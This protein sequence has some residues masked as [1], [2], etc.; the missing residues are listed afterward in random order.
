M[1]RLRSRLEARQRGSSGSPRTKRRRWSPEERGG[2]SSKEWV[3]FERGFLAE[4]RRRDLLDV[5]PR[6]PIFPKDRI[7]MNLTSLAN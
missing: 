7:K 4:E 5:Q 6:F 3:T 1:R 2:E